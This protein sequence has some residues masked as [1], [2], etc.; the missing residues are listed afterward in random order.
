MRVLISGMATATMAVTLALTP[1]AAHAAEPADCFS[2]S[3]DLA[4]R[5]RV[6]KNV[7]ADAEMAAV[8]TSRAVTVWAE[9]ADGTRLEPE[10][11]PIPGRESSEA[12]NIAGR[13][14]TEGLDQASSAESEELPETK[15]WKCTIINEYAADCTYSEPYLRHNPSTGEVFW[16]RSIS[17]YVKFDLQQLK[18]SVTYRITNDQGIPI[19]AEGHL[20]LSRMQ[21]LLV[22]TTEDEK[23]WEFYTPLNQ[24][25]GT[26]WLDRTDRT[27]GKYSIAFYFDEF[28]DSE[29]DMT[30]PFNG[31]LGS[32]PRF[33]CYQYLR[34]WN[35]KNCEWPN[36][37]EAGVF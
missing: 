17:V 18:H 12:P 37:Q 8:C 23:T 28:T 31:Y 9:L 27:E 15:P 1:S 2:V 30:Y 32:T 7:P 33:Q 35:T 25:K 36:A 20:K 13:S 11:A 4:D 34:I 22:A 5:Y 16:D 24:L 26:S 19:T 10:G 3:R 21:G 6:T 14:L 29:E